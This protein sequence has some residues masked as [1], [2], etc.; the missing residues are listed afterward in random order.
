[1]HSSSEAQPYSEKWTI[2][3]GNRETKSKRRNTMKHGNSQ[4]FLQNGLGEDSGKNYSEAEQCHKQTELKI[5]TLA[6]IW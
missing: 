6:M 3:T 2:K 1:M 5:Q 4:I